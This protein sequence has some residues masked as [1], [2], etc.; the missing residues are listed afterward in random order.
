MNDGSVVTEQY[1]VRFPDLIKIL[2]SSIVIKA[3]FNVLISMSC[4]ISDVF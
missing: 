3:F 2:F 4:M 1:F